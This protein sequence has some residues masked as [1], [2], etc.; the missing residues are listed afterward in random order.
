MNLG[1][2]RVLRGGAGFFRLEGRGW[3]AVAGDDRAD[4]LQ[5]LLTNDVAAL[6]PGSGCYAACLTPQGRM[7]ADMF[8][9]ADRE[10]LLLDVDGGVADRLRER[11]EELVFTEDVRID[12]LTPG[13]AAYAVHGP[14]AGD[15]AAALTGGGAPRLAV[16]GHRAVDFKAGAGWLARTDDLGVE[17]YRVVVERPAAEPLRRA[18]AAAGAVAVEP[19]AA[20]V[21]RVESG[22]PRF[23]ADLDHDT[24]PLEAGIADRAISFDK[25]CYVGQEVIVRIL[26]RGQGR[27]ARRLAGLTFERSAAAD[28]PLPASGAAVFRGGE[29]V[30]R[31]TSAVRSPAAGAVIAL[32]YV[33][34]ELAEAEGTGV[35][36]ALGAGRAPA[37]VTALPFV[38][39][40]RRGDERGP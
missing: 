11:F 38:S 29:Q 23:P 7:T 14:G 6:A 19:A 28:A 31:V 5:G 36:V 33:R 3:L 2:H 21:V 20:E 37:V 34:R 22:R 39:A 15:V 4:F 16:C 32:G 8:V 9:F 30:G 12:D 26:H 13:W 17:G 10:R 35:D 18:L 40:A 24:I 27:V 25:G 1:D